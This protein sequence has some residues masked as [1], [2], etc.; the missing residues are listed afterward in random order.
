MPDQNQPVTSTEAQF[1]GA[2]AAAVR[3]AMWTPVQRFWRDLACLCPQR[4]ESVRAT[5]RT[6]MQANRQRAEQVVTAKVPRS[7]GVVLTQTHIVELMLDLVDYRAEL[8]LG[9]RTLL[10]PACGQG[11]FVEIALTRLLRSVQQTGRPLDSL[12]SALLAFELDHAQVLLT[13]QRLLSVLRQAGVPLRLAKSLVATWVRHADF[14]LASE[15]P[16]VDVVVGNPPYVRLEQLDPDRRAAY[17]AQHASLFD[18]A[19]LYV[20][21]IE[22]ALS[23]LSPHGRLSFVCA[24]RWTRNRYGG[25]LRKLISDR[26]QVRCYIDLSQS[27]PF[28]ATVQAYPSIFVLGQKQSPPLD[29]VPVVTM[30]RADREECARA[31]ALLAEGQPTR[32]GHNAPSLQLHREWFSGDAPWVIVDPEQR[33]LLVQLEQRFATL[34]DVGQTQLG[35]G[36]ATGCDDVLIVDEAQA[37]ALEAQTRL[38]LVMRSDLGHGQIAW[39][40]RYVLQTF[41]PDG[42]PLDLT[43]HPQLAQYVERHR[44]VLSARY[45]ARRQPQAWFRTIDRVYPELVYTPKLLIPDIASANELTLDPGRY[46]PHHNLYYVTSQGW[47]LATLGGLLSSQVAL[48]FVWSYA[49]TLRGGYLRFQAQ[50]LRR[51][52]VPHPRDV[53]RPL[54]AD[55]A[56][57][58]VQRDFA[59][60]DVLAA[61]AY[62]LAAPPQ[63]DFVDTRT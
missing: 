24:D 43:Q 12:G 28:D 58:F 13:R 6:T 25:P 10:E 8:D 34:E 55:L 11:A 18:R 33:R 27:S 53:P 62:G 52:R 51:I 26:C 50:Y 23:Q 60:M 44:D 30:Q 35:I 19:D 21:F 49:V 56:R 2:D 9:A 32:A 4:D 42:R 7:P 16:Q 5:M 1:E 45:V 54:A 48:F 47:D 38:P 15:L 40:R 22:R 57:A 14:L 59:A 39:G 61:R 3:C 46:Y 20:A 41:A 37:Q 36:V 29:A 31:L 17:R 63:F